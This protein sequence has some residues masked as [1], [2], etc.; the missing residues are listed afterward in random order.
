MSSIPDFTEAEQW[1]D[2]T[3]KEGWPGQ[4]HEIQLAD[5]EIRC[6]RENAN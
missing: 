1:A 5:V 3:L 4:E 2:T 6:T